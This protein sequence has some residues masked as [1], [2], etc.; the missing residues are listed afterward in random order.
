MLNQ[1]TE[2][3]QKYKLIRPWLIEHRARVEAELRQ[4]KRNNFPPNIVIERLLDHEARFVSS[5]LPATDEIL[6]NY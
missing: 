4:C 3:I 1:T 2:E 6:F 5:V